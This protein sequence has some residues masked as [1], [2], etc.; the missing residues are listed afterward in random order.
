MSQGVIVGIGGG[1]NL[2]VICGEKPLYAVN[3]TIWLDTENYGNVTIDNI[4]PASPSNGDVWMEIDKIS[5]VQIVT[6]YSKASSVLRIRDAK[7][8]DGSAWK[9]IDAEIMINDTWV[10][11]Y[12]HVYLDGDPYIDVTGGWLRHQNGENDTIDKVL[13]ITAANGY[14]GTENKVSIAGYN[15]LTVRNFSKRGTSATANRVLLCD[16]ASIAAS[17]V[18][19]TLGWN[20][21]S[22][23]EVSVVLDRSVLTD[24]AYYIFFTTAVQAT[25][26]SPVTLGEIALEGTE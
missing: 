22:E 4:V 25:V 18:K 15:R 19:A 21:S 14:I 10:K 17:A 1:K 3:N 16:T 13:K 5:R 24:D 8:Y 26:A 20:S 11:L 12:Q 23:D 9:I 6:Q 7:Q 2:F